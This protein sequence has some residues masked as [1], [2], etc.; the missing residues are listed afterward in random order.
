MIPSSKYFPTSLGARAD[1]YNNFATQFETVAVDLGFTLSDVTN[2]ENDNLMMQFLVNA[3]DQM[4]AV[5]DA[6]RQFRTV[7]TEGAPGSPPPI[8]PTQFAGMPPLPLVPV[9]LFQRLDD[10]VKRIR[11]SPAYSPEI[12]AL[13]GIIPSKTPESDPADMKPNPS[14]RAEPGNTI[15]VD[16]TRGK[17]D[18]IDIQMMLDNSGNWE[19]AG[20]YFKSPASIIVTQGAQALPRAVQIRARYVIGN[21]AV[22][23]FSDIDTISTIP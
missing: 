20:K 23:Q 13:L 18:G 15:L 14:V 11:V 6:A 17:S 9:G 7:M 4:N 19:N 21:N 2:V 16:F 3:N 22:G 8:W 10:L 5:I 12:G 1:W